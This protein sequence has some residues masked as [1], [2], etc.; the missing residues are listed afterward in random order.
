MMA[1]PMRALLHLLPVCCGLL[2]GS[3][4]HAQQLSIDW[5][6]P[7]NCPDQAELRARIAQLLA[8]SGSHVAHVQVQGQINRAEDGW[9]LRLELTLDAQPA[10]RL[11]RARDC[12]S[13]SAATVGLVAIAL[14]PAIAPDVV[15]EPT[16]P[17][18]APDG[19]PAPSQPEAANAGNA[20]PV[21]DPS[22]PNAPPAQSAPAADGGEP[23]RPP[24]PPVATPVL[25]W[26]LGA[27][28]G[29]FSAGLPGPQATA[30]LRVGLALEDILVDLSA[31]DHFARSQQLMAAGARTEYET[32]ELALAGCRVWGETWRV[33]PCLVLSA[34]RTRGSASGFAGAVAKQVFWGT[35][36]A[37]ALVTYSVS[38][39][40]ELR[41]DAGLWLPIT[42]R[43]L[44]VLGIDNRE[45][46]VGDTTK[47][48][49]FARLGLG[50]RL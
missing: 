46:A 11:L 30:G 13:L 7:A 5:Q 3:P 50:L 37:S 43:P 25:S 42:R 24:R 10:V 18:K 2:V 35:L 31:M 9:T 34:L 16:Q 45:A 4:V 48:G 20:A 39:Y 22:R 8:D 32:Q 26:R 40:L 49:L 23:A 14:Q 28:G 21:T 27:F 19:V 17:A 47:L 44:F 41:L 38:D 12:K 1:R 36:G 15:P 6:A 29:V 33:G